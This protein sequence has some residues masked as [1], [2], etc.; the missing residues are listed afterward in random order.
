M[1]A[2]VDTSGFFAPPPGPPAP[3]Q[4]AASDAGPA[5]AAAWADMADDGTTRRAPTPGIPEVTLVLSFDTGESLVVR[6]TGLIGR[7]PQARRADGEVV[8]LVPVNDPAMSVSKTHLV[9]GLS[10]GNLWIQDRESTNGTVVV[11]ADESEEVASAGTRVTV[12]IGD[13]V[14]FGERSFK[15]RGG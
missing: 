8:H 10:G 4:P 15:V 5:S 2:A 6:G 3:G 1:G 13:A 12:R 14:R 9:F 11:R 7:R